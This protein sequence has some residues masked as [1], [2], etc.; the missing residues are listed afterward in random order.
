MTAV[1]EKTFD[2][3]VSDIGEMRLVVRPLLPF[4]AEGFRINGR[5]IEVFGDGLVMSRPIG[6]E[7]LDE[8]DDIERALLIE[9]G[10]TGGESLRET[11]LERE[12]SL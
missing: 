8:I 3:L 10:T 9:F 11:E 1:S 5:D 12:D 4:H 7:I 2:I 6:G